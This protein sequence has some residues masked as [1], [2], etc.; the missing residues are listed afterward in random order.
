MARVPPNRS[1]AHARD[2]DAAGA[3]P[4]GP[5]GTADRSGGRIGHE[6]RIGLLTFLLRSSKPGLVLF[7]H[8]LAER[9]GDDFVSNPSVHI[10]VSEF[11]RTVRYLKELGF[12]FIAMERLIELSQD[13]F[14][15]DRPWIHLTFDDGYQSN[16]T[17][18]QPLL[19]DMRIPWTLFVSTGHVDRGEP[20]YTYQIRCAIMHTGREARFPSAAQTLA[21]NASRD[22]RIRYYE[23]LGF[24]KLDKA[25]QLAT[26]EYARSLLEPAAWGRLDEQ[27]GSERMLTA[28]E[29]RQLAQDPLVHIGTHNHNHIVLGRAVA[30]ADAAFE[31]R[32]SRDWLA[33]ELGEPVLTYAYPNGERTDFSAET[34]D[35]CR[36]LG[37][38]LAF[39]G[40]SEPVSAATDPFEIPRISIPPTFKRAK[41]KFARCVVRHAMRHPRGG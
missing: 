4:G 32:T 5:Q 1:E 22:E 38:R 37:Y 8:G 12:E 3:A 34:G 36:S 25:G 10:D 7:G 6:R 33:R 14:A 2:D 18:L 24:K 28:E 30:E 29:L 21:A 27:Y 11:E 9:Y 17:L 31:M 23:S 35:A 41:R 40:V 20:M 26:V 13:R 39:T 19:G 15:H 16:L